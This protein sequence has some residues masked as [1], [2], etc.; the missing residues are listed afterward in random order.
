MHNIN[1][2][3]DFIP[4]VLGSKPTAALS[5]AAGELTKESVISISDLLSITLQEKTKGYMLM[6]GAMNHILRD[7]HIKQ[8]RETP[9]YS[10]HKDVNH[11]LGRTI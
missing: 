5:R 6:E 10:Y 9:I 4:R 3:Q 8:W 7:E 11:K 2:N 1:L